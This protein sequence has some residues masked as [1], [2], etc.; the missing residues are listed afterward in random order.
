MPVISEFKL[1]NKI[2]VIAGNGQGW[3]PSIAEALIEAGAIVAIVGEN[4]NYLN[5]I[6]TKTNNLYIT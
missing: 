4:Q 2:A 6:N 1:N 5:T 3:G